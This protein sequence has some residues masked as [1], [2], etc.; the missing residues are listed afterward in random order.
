MTKLKPG[1]RVDCRVRSAIIVSPYKGYDEE[2]TFEVVATDSYGYY[3]FVPVYLSLKGSVIADANQ[4][5]LLGIDRKFLDE[6]IIYIQENLICR[7][8]SKLDGMRCVRC[9]DFYVMA[10][11]NQDNDTFMCWSCR[12]NPYR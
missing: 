1:D 3:L 6:Q 4:C 9:T 8:H 2:R 7:V 5:K 11:P 10:S 12:N